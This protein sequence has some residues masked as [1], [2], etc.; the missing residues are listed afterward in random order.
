M[1]DLLIPERS[2][3]STE[4]AAPMTNTCITSFARASSLPVPVYTDPESARIANKLAVE[5]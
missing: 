3:L 1:R 4:C 2:L 5:V